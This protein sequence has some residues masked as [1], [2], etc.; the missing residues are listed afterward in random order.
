MARFITALWL[1]N[2]TFAN[3]YQSTFRQPKRM[4]YW[5]V[6]ASTELSW[7]AWDSFALT[8]TGPLQKESS[9]KIAS[10]NTLKNVKEEITEIMW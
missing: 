4:F 8:S 2:T 6:N 3:F 7:L 10:R 9:E 1:G 5:T